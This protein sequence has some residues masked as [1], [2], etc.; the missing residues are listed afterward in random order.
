MKF[1]DLRAC[2]FCGADEMYRRQYMQ[3]P[4]IF[5]FSLTGKETDNGAM[6]DTVTVVYESERVYCG[7]CGRYIG[8]IYT[9][10]LSRAAQNEISRRK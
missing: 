2:P 6:F 5:R 10:E 7:D 1:E 9:G 4:A 8:N 3:G